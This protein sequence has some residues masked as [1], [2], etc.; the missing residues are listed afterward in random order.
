MTTLIVPGAYTG[1]TTEEKRKQVVTAC[2][3]I[4]GGQM[5]WPSSA[6]VQ[7]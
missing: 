2:H 3:E 5:P 7:I 1:P 4:G 6:M